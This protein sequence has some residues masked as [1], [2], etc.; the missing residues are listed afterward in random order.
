MHSNAV[1]YTQVFDFS[2]QSKE[3]AERGLSEAVPRRN[4]LVRLSHFLFQQHNL[5]HLRPTPS[6]CP[7]KINPTRQPRSRTIRNRRVRKPPPIDHIHLAP[8]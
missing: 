1:Y 2:I 6:L 5:P 3:P 8:Q 7:H 4:P